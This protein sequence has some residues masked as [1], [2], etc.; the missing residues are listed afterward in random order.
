MRLFCKK[1]ISGTN[2][3]RYDLFCEIQCTLSASKRFA[4]SHN[5]N[6]KLKPYESCNPV[7]CIGVNDRMTLFVF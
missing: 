3:A 2:T 1:I 6:P 5:P 7:G 4:A